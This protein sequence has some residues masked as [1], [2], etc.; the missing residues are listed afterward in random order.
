[1]LNYILYHI[2]PVAH[3]QFCALFLKSAFH[4]ISR[5]LYGIFNSTQSFHKPKGCAPLILRAYGVK[6]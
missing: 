2:G 6:W 4:K 5:N 1:M 3:K